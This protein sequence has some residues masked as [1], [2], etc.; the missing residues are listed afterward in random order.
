MNDDPTPSLARQRALQS[1]DGRGREAQGDDH[2]EDPGASGDAE[3]QKRRRAG[4]EKK[5]KSIT[6]LQKGL[7]MVVF[8]YICTLYY[9][10]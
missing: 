3:R 4:L 6:D 8:I 9:M 5:L 1:E 2:T 10:E 7:D